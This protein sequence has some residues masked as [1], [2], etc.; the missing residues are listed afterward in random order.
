M[1]FLHEASAQEK[2]SSRPKV[3]VQVDVDATSI[4]VQGCVPRYFLVIMVI[5]VTSQAIIPSHTG[6]EQTQEELPARLRHGFH[7]AYIGEKGSF[8]AYKD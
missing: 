4:R 1:K 3:I 5:F 8:W 6:A 2:A 7:G